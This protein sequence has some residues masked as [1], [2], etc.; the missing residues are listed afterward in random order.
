M[1]RAGLMR[2]RVTLQVEQEAPDG[3]GGY[4]LAWHDVATVWGH[5][6][7]ERGRERLESGRIEGALGAVLKVRHSADTERVNPGWRAVIDGVEYNITSVSQ[8]DRR[9]RVVE[10]TVVRGVAI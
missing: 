9:N 3:G 2:D 10:M 4:V 8:P 6:T 5:L 7:E 1:A